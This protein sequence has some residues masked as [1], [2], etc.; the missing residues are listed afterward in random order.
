MADGIKNKALYLVLQPPFSLDK[1]WD[2]ADAQKPSGS[3]GELINYIPDRGVLITRDGVTTLTF[4][5]QTS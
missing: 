4:V 1:R 5:A 2:N 3:F